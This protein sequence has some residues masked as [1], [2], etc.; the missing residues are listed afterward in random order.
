MGG[1]CH[2]GWYWDALVKRCITCQQQCESPPIHARCTSYCES[3]QCKKLPGRHYDGLLKTCIICAEVCGRHPAECSQHCQSEGL[4]VPTLALEDPTVLLY[5]LLALCMVLLFSSLSLT[6]A[7]F[8]RGSRAKTSKPGPKEASQNQERLVQPGKEVRLPVGHL[9]QT[10]KDFVTSPSCPTDR[11]PSEDT[12]PTETCVCVHCF[13]DLK[14]LGQG[15]DR[16]P[17]APFSFYQQAVLPTA[18]KFYCSISI[19]I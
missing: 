15:N 4:P 8:L 7:V 2:E 5:S 11:E 12:S 16:P 19:S 1:R 9:G 6:L 13:P 3:A 18:V 17:R 14:A 10:S